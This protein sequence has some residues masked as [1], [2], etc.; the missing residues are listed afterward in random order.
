MIIKVM[1]WIYDPDPKESDRDDLQ[2]TRSCNLKSKAPIMSFYLPWTLVLN[3]L[4]QNCI[5][6]YDT[7]HIAM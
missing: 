4:Q 7:P 3:F 6:K 2:A 5:P 1:N